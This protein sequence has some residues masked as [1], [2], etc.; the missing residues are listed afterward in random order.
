[1][2]SKLCFKIIDLNLLF[3]YNMN[4]YNKKIDAVDIYYTLTLNFYESLFGCNKKISIKYNKICDICKGL[5]KINSTFCD[6]CKDK[7]NKECEKCHG[8][9]VI[10]LANCPICNDGIMQ[11]T[12]E[13]TLKIRKGSNEQTQYIIKDFN[14]GING[15]K[16]GNLY[17]SLKIH[18]DTDFKIINTYDIKYNLTISL[19]D[20]IFGKII[21]IPTIHQTHFK[22]TIQPFTQQNDIITLKSL[23]LLNEKTK[24]YGNM[25][26]KINVLIP[27]KLNNQQL[28]TLKKI[29]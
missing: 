5:G 13:I 21:A 14:L 23:G 9:G 29:L 6:I 3:L 10:F 15:G 8:S 27:D 2:Y 18:N 16:N 4:I 22:L 26:I 28:D 7:P 11:T 25:I 1:M 12:K 19:K 17:V 20:A 24:E